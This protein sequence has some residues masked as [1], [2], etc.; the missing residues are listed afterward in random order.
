MN[1]GA[2][3]SMLIWQMEMEHKT[4]QHFDAANYS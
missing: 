4:E 2:Q 1:L 3:V